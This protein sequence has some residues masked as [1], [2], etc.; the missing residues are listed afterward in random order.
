MNNG[1]KTQMVSNLDVRF[2]N[3]SCRKL[4][5]LNF[6]PFG[7]VSLNFYRIFP[8]PEN[9]ND[10][11][12]STLTLYAQNHNTVNYGGCCIRVLDLFVSNFAA[13]E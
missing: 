12:I 10:I 2:L 6:Y 11:R 3:A 9:F 7:T 8:N 4:W 1:A 5:Y 13:V